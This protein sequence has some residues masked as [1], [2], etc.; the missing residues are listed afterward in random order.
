[1]RKIFMIFVFMLFSLQV[2]ADSSV[3]ASRILR[4]YLMKQNYND[5]QKQ[6]SMGK[7]DGNTTT[8]ITMSEDTNTFGFDYSEMV[9]ENEMY[10][11][12]IS[13]NPF[14][15]EDIK[16][17]KFTYSFMDSEHEERQ[18]IINGEIT[19]DFPESELNITNFI[20]NRMDQ[21]VF[22]YY[23]TQNRQAIDNL[24]FGVKEKVIE[25]LQAIDEMFLNTPEL[26]EKNIDIR[27]IGFLKIE[28]KENSARN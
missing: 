16:T 28:Q 22:T 18:F 24:T 25:A 7:T 10:H 3:N 21:G 13:Y 4:S 15:N 6:Y 1:M 8:T 11:I 23:S 19:T 9:N 5:V 27:S 20:G 14:T 12:L 17:A 26:T 2:M